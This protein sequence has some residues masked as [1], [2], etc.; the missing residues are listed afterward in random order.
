MRFKGTMNVDL[1]DIITNLVPFPK[2]NLLSTAMSPLYLL[3]DVKKNNIDA[4]FSQAYSP[5]N[6]LL[7]VN[8]KESTYLATALLVRGLVDI[9]DIRKN[10]DRL[11]TQ[12]RF[13]PWNVDAWKTGLCDIPPLGQVFFY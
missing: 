12:F 3:P 13:V 5:E 11:R 7:S 9:S 4:V 8:P 2:L 1:S 6:Q 10:I